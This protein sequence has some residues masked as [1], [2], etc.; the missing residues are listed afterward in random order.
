MK[1][2]LVTPEKIAFEAETTSV[3]V[4]T[5]MGEITILPHHA[6]LTGQ[7]GSGELIVRDSTSEHVFAVN[8]GFISVANDEIEVLAESADHA[9]EI[10]L[11]KAEEARARA[12]KLRE[13]AQGEM[14]IADATAALG[15]A[16]AQIKVAQRKHRHHART[17]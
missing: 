15:R 6:A 12:E 5:V 11:Q 4:P 13:E 16:L 2:R 8:G 10:D 7:L 17:P 9:D 1:F 14:E 3:S